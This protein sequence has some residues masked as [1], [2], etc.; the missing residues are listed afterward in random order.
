[1]LQISVIYNQNWSLKFL[2][3]TRGQF[4]LMWCI[5]SVLQFDDYQI[6]HEFVKSCHDFSHVTPADCVVKASTHLRCHISCGETNATENLKHNR[7]TECVTVHVFVLLSHI[8][9]KMSDQTHSACVAMCFLLWAIKFPQ[10][11]RFECHPNYNVVALHYCE[12]MP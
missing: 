3:C 8:L 9:G 4:Y 11:N 5:N 7:C 6:L 12:C 10:S 2:F 1:M